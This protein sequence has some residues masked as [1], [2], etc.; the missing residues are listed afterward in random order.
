M[1]FQAF[2]Q[3]SSP[4]QAAP[5]GTLVGESYVVSG[6]VSSADGTAIEGASVTLENVPN[7]PAQSVSTDAAGVYAVAVDVAA[8]DVPST[9]DVVVSASGHAGQLK[10]VSVTQSE[11]AYTVDFSLSEQQRAAPASLAHTHRLSQS[12]A[13][14]SFQGAPAD[15]A[16]S[17]RVTVSG[18]SVAYVEQP[19]SLVHVQR[20]AS[21]TGEAR[22]RISPADVQ[23]AQKIESFQALV[24][25]TATTADV[26][27]APRYSVR[28]VCSP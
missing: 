15:L 5:Q 9:W 8:E 20:L 21:T 7:V 3:G 1:P 4:F 18:G 10:Q 16:H 13:A 19:T 11:T 26:T 14:V 12:S 27:V 2:P 22:S 17:Q 23:H 25:G 28:I 6:T 24:P